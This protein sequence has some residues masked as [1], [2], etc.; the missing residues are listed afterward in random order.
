MGFL[1]GKRILITGM[2]SSRSIAYG[3]AKAM[4]REGAELAFTY[5][6]ERVR[7]RVAKLATEFGG[8]PIFVCDVAEDA[9]IE[10]LFAD[11]GKLWG[12]LDSLVHAIAYAPNE[13]LE[14]DFLSGLTRDNFR[15]AH[16]VSAYSFPALAKGARPLM[17]GRNGSL[18]TLSYLGA[19]RTVPYYNVMGPAKASLEASV[20]YLAACLGAEGTRVNAISAGPIKTLAA[21]AVANFGKLLSINSNNAPLRRN[22]T[23]EEVGNAAAFLCSDLASGITGEI[24]YVDAG[25]NTTTI[26]HSNNGS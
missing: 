16:E 12:G 10:A 6:S 19:M 7:E 17:Q 4:H 5:Q 9:Q 11:I 1:S 15:I 2:I 23:I 24:M 3:I 13:A 20:R 21:S 22:V 26:A 25:F 14:G 8:P 18:L